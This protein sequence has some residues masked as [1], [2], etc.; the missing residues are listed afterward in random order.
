MRDPYDLAPRTANLL[1]LDLDNGTAIGF[2]ARACMR[3][4]FDDRVLPRNDK[5]R[6]RDALCALLP[7]KPKFKA[8]A[9]D[10]AKLACGETSL[11]ALLAYELPAAAQ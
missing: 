6:V 9:V 5:A 4:G 2:D 7:E 8:L 1:D 11:D 3:S 10:L